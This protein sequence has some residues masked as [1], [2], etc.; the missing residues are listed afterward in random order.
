MRPGRS[1][2][3]VKV[4]TFH[5]RVA[6]VEMPTDGVCTAGCLPVTPSGEVIVAQPADCTR[7]A[8]SAAKPV[9]EKYLAAAKAI[10]GHFQMA[11]VD[12]FESAGGTVLFQEVTFTPR[13][14]KMCLGRKLSPS[15]GQIWAYLGAKRRARIHP[16]CVAQV[17]RATV[18]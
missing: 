13:N 15:T 4:Y 5:G 18:C 9:P 1:L 16:R 8:D 11:R 7:G 12:F 14:C 3:D 2:R 6:A 10:G 17:A